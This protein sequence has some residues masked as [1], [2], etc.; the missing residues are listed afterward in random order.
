[1]PVDTEQAS[2][3][4]ATVPADSEQCDDM[5]D[6]RIMGDNEISRIREFA[7]RYGFYIIPNNL[8]YHIA[9]ESEA[10]RIE[11][12]SS[13]AAAQHA[14][15]LEAL[16][17]DPTKKVQSLEVLIEKLTKT[18]SIKVHDILHI[19]GLLIARWSCGHTDGLDKH[20]LTKEDG[21]ISRGTFSRYMTRDRFTI[22]LRYLHFQ[23]SSVEHGHFGEDIGWAR[24]SFDE[25][26][27]PNR[28]KVNPVRGYNKDKPHKYG[29]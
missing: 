8:W 5:E 4:D 1:M 27:I 17:K 13:V 19:V 14:K 22:I 23:S 7:V 26:T 16:A 9:K 11:C 28:S 10:Y 12:I 15:Q 29:T 24:I 25:G 2:G 20:W 21:A 3:M 6:R 18:R